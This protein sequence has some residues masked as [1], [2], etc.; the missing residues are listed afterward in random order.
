MKNKRQPAT[1]RRPAARLALFAAAQLAALSCGSAYATSPD[2]C[3]TL[4]GFSL[5]ASLIGKPSSGAVVQSAVFVSGE[6]PGNPHGAY[7]AVK[8]VVKP[9]SAG[10]PDLEFQVNLPANWN[11]RALQMGGGGYDGT[12]VTGLG[13]FTM[14]PAALAHP[15]KQGYVTLGSDGGHKGQGS[16]DGTFALNA[17]ALANYGQLSVKKAHDVA[18]ALIRQYYNAVPKYFYFIGG[19][20]GGHEA[21][22]AA[23]RYPEDYD[24]VIANYPAYNITLLQLA[25]LNAGR[26]MYSG[27]GAGWLGKAKVKLLTDAVYAACDTVALDGAKD[28]I[29]SNVAGCNA[30]FN[31][32]TVKATLRCPGGADSGDG[33][34]SDAQ[35][36]TVQ[37]IAS[38]YDAGFEIA[39]QRVFP[40]WPLLEGALFNV[41]SFGA[42]AQ[43]ANPPAPTDALLYAIGAAHAKYLVTQDP[44]LDAMRYDPAAWKPRLQQLGTITDVTA[45][46]LAAFRAKGGKLIL[47][48]GTA[49]DFISPHNTA[50]YYRA[51]VAAL[52]QDAVDG[53]VRYYV[54]PGFGHGFGPFK[55]AYDGLAVL[56]RW[57]AQGEAP[58]TL[59]ASDNNTGASRTRPM[60]RYPAW[61]KFTGAAGASADSA[62]GFSCVR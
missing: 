32:D 6:A 7:C 47:T 24:G 54:V 40:R 3:S 2:A 33:C 31:L 19:S 8:G 20:Q 5:P 18:L 55:A 50:D 42:A 48:H 4:A 35:I 60:C 59:S 36:A 46:S 30:A 14:Q 9:A 39:G 28:G 43:P 17:E 41:S 51:Q 16:F 52:G 58:E 15:L 29:I 45:V 49:D 34:L 22:D 26:A 21:L 53:F 23:A 13:P 38:P 11:A 37:A 56:D 62:A 25:S 10:A 27:G 44:A 61:P 12:L 57:V 1:G